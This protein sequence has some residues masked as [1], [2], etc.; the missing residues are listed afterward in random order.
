MRNLS[1]YWI[2]H[3]VNFGEDHN[4]RVRA[5]FSKNHTVDAL[6][7]LGWNRAEA[8]EAADLV[9]DHYPGRW[10]RVRTKRDPGLCVLLVCVSVGE[11]TSK[12]LRKFW[13]PFSRKGYL[14]VPDST[15][16]REFRPQLRP[17]YEG[18]L[19]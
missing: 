4:V 10:V 8:R 5:C 17:S 16:L 12:L 15:H 18:E 2:R 7:E 6:R 3:T 11:V 13:K 1:L 19:L 14:S 9:E